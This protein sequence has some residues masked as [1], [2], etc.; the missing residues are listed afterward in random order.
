M[1]V[2]KIV[3]NPLS[4]EQT[5]VY[6]KKIKYFGLI[7]FVKNYN[8]MKKKEDFG[9]KWGDEVEHY[10]INVEKTSKTASLCLNGE[11]V[12]K[13]LYA[14]NSSL[15]KKQQIDWRPEYSEFMVESSP[16][17]PYGDSLDQ[18]AHVE[19]NM[20]IRRN[21]ALEVLNKHEKMI[22][23]THFPLI[24]CKKF[25]EPAYDV[26]PE[27]NDQ[28]TKSIFFPSQAIGRHPRFEAFTKAMYKRKGKKLTANIPIYLDTN[29]SSPFKET[30]T[31]EE[32]KC[33]SLKNHIYMDTTLLAFSSCSVQVTM[34]AA[35]LK[36]ATNLY[37]QL[38]V[39]SPIMHALSASSPFYRGYVSDVDTRWALCTQLCDDRSDEE[40]S[41]IKHSRYSSVQLYLSQERSKL[42]DVGVAVNSE[43]YDYLVSQNVNKELAKHVAHLWVRD[44]LILFTDETDFESDETYRS[45]ENIQSTVWQDLRFKPPPHPHSDIGW[46]VEFRPLEAQPSE[47]ENSAFVCFVV[48][49]ARALVHFEVDLTM[50]MSMVHRNMEKAQGNDACRKTLFSF[51]DSISSSDGAENEKISL[52]S[53]DAI[54]NGDNDSFVGL[55]GLVNKFMETQSV[56]Q[57]TLEKVQSYLNHISSIASG[58]V[59]TTAQKMRHFVRNH[60]DYKKDS[61]ISSKINFDMMKSIWK[62]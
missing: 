14:L 20:L 53:I 30:F 13:K 21:Q 45:F 41:E 40:L 25:T 1:G 19:D 5:K 59:L 26:R 11:K 39:L 44:P 22:T 49:L 36:Q 15:P 38:A 28:V 56:N 61:K 2:L 4:W 29:T 6:S 52:M 46:R 62:V 9:F 12:L 43:A 58:K 3:G 42:N 34:Q 55:V 57:V 37:D 51:C 33:S 8:R 16:I 17:T 18:L 31:N 48:L 10:I 60:E 50:P 23:M 35:K 27:S 47:F 7:Q 54:V 32:D 24:G